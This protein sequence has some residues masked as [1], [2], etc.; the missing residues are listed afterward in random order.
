MERRGFLKVAAAGA[1]AAAGAAQSA[2][3]ADF[4]IRTPPHTTEEGGMKF[5]ILGETGQRVSLIGLGGFHLAKPERNAPTTEDAIRI[6]R[7]FL[8]AGG[9]FCDNCWDYNGGESEVRLGKALRDGYRQK[10]FVMTKI[11]GRTRE[12][13]A[14]Q[15][16]TS[17]KRLQTDHID[18]LQFHEIIRMQDPE[19]IFAPGGALE[20]VLQARQD[21]KIRHIGFTGHKSPAI[22]K[23]M[24][25]VAAAH[26]FHF[27]TVQM[28][29]NIM[30]AHFNS[31]QDIIFPV[32]EAQKTAVLAMKT[33]GDTFIV[34]S[35]V[36]DPIEMLHYSM[37]QP[38]AVVVT[39]CDHM[40]ILQQALTA[41]R[42]YQPMTAAQQQALLQ[43]SFAKAQGGQTERYK[44]STHFDGTTQHPNWLTEG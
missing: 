9:N 30:D 26:G 40:Q 6:V 36:A 13:A 32:A 42:S 2:A 27:D 21:G 7:T 41:V 39:G 5:R 31:F 4:A 16:D 18:L 15:I 14:A 28:P 23:H 22:H 19:R 11:D 3:A 20:A 25:E 35:H 24:F 33:F 34:D 44:V 38:V 12:S 43:K 10:A 17:L 8:D 1:T 37:S 29:V